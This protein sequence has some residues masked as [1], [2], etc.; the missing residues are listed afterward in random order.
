MEA[1][2]FGDL[3]DRLRAASGH[4]RQP[5]IQNL[6]MPAPGDEDIGRL[7]VTVDDAFRMCGIQSIGN[8]DSERQHHLDV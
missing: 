6:G 3:G 7:D 1:A 2:G 8:F 4:L 5:K